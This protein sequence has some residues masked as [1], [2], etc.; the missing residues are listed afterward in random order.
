MGYVMS[1]V[2]EI[3]LYLKVASWICG[4]VWLWIDERRMR[5]EGAAERAVRA[6]ELEKQ[7]SA[8]NEAGPEAASLFSNDVE[9]RFQPVPDAA[10]GRRPGA[11]A[12]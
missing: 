2:F 1:K 8:V 3:F 11:E 6:E 5:R 12:S 4:A 7:N 10:A 9:N